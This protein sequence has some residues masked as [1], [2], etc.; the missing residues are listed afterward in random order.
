MITILVK[1]CYLLCI[2]LYSQER[3]KDQS[4]RLNLHTRYK[5]I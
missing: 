3:K 5:I 1:T 2:F 4:F